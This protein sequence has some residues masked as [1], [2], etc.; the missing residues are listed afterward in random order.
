MVR[1]LRIERLGEGEAQR[2]ERRGPEEREARRVA[3]LAPLKG[4]QEYVAAV[5]EPREAQRRILRRPRHREERLEAA[6]GLAVA[7]DRRAVDVLRAERE[8]TIA[9]HGARAA[10][11]EGLEE[12]QRLAGNAA[13]GAELAAREEGEVAVDR[14]VGL[15]L[16]AQAHVL[17][18]A[19]GHLARDT[20]QRARA[21]G[22]QAVPGVAAPAAGEG[23]VAVFV[24]E[25]LREPEVDERAVVE[26]LQL[27]ALDIQPEVDA[28]HFRHRIA[29]LHAAAD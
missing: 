2:T 27:R 13:R 1:A 28:A 19:F 14:E 29:E 11:E 21:R 3:Q 4:L 20:H 6:G 22:D 8:R 15:V 12:R 25:V 10:G 18:V 26:G 7:A 9:A 23:A 16:V 5:D 24:A 17:Q